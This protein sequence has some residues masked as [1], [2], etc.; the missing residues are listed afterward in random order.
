MTLKDIMNADMGTVGQWVAAG[1]R[2]WTAE[3]AGMLPQR[4]RA[5]A[6]RGG[7]HALA[8]GR[9]FRL[10]RSG[11]LHSQPGTGKR[12]RRIT[13]A[14]PETAAFRRQVELPILGAADL[15]RMVEHDIDRLTPFAG[16]SV[17]FDIAVIER[18]PLTVLADLAVIPRDRLVRRLDEARAAGIEPGRIALADGEGR[19]RFDLLRAMRLAGGGKQ[20]LPPAAGWWIAVAGLV[21]LLLAVVI[22]RD[23]IALSRLSAAVEAEAPIANAASGLRRRVVAEQAR[24]QALARRRA[25]HDPLPILASLSD[26]MPGGAWVQRLTW[27]GVSLRLTGYKPEAVDIIAALRSSP[28]L[29]KVR[30]SATEA[31]A[32]LAAGQPF[33]V[34]ADRKGR[35]K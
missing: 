15:R 32:T 30:E 1:W 6:G 21:A 2:W 33:D 13:L 26:V 31:P 9:N 34:E 12:P 19:T 5:S 25:E 35:S 27:N 22:G 29:D 18:R 24:R 28:L 23:M 3:L 10:A 8:E 20:P 4:L 16:D 14:L 17:Y 11:R 7:D